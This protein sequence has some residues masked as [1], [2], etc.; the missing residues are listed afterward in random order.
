MSDR[1][2]L[3]PADAVGVVRTTATAL[4]ILVETGGDVMNDAAIYAV[5]EIVRILPNL[6]KGRFNRRHMMADT[7]RS[8]LRLQRVPDA[9]CQTAYRLVRDCDAEPR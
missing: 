6:A 4:R 9:L 5:A 3:I 7:L 1:K 8:D 2:V